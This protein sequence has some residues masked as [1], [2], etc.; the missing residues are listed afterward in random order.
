MVV[1]ENLWVQKNVVK[2]WN[3]IKKMLVLKNVGIESFGLKK[4]DSKTFFG[5]D[6]SWDLKKPLN[7]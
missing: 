4:L 1:Q 3:W 7:L 5:G 6:L 2:Q